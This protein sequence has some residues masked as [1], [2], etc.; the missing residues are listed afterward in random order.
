MGGYSFLFYF[1]AFVILYF[2]NSY[3]RIVSGDWQIDDFGDENNAA[4]C[5][6]STSAIWKPFIEYIGSLIS[7]GSSIP[8][9]PLDTY[10]EVRIKEVLEKANTI[11]GSGKRFKV[12]TDWNHEDACHLQ[13]MGELTGIAR[14][15]PPPVMWSAHPKYG[16]W[17]AFRAVIVFEG[18]AAPE[19]DVAKPPLVRST[20]SNYFSFFFFFFIIVCTHNKSLSGIDSGDDSGDASNSRRVQGNWMVEGSHSKSQ[21]PQ[22]SPQRRSRVL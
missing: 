10:N 3:N 17:F 16:I 9:N 7:N 14:Y 1:F 15:S 8:Q 21:V 2:H 6:A 5:I 19:I 4:I 20:T 13:T 22:C 11:I 18:L 12:Y